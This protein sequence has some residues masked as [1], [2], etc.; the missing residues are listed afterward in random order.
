M[1][2]RRARTPS[3]NAAQ[4]AIELGR[5][6]RERRHVS[7]KT[8]VRRVVLVH[9]DAAAQAGLAE[10]REYVADELNALEVD[11][12]GD[13]A[14]WCTYVA[15]PDNAGLGKRLGADF[16]RVLPLIKALG[17]AEV[18]GFLET[19]SVTVGG[20]TLTGADLQARPRGG[21]R[22]GGGAAAPDPPLPACPPIAGPARGQGGARGA[23]RGGRLGGGGPARRRRRPPGAALGGGGGRAP[24]PR[25][26]PP[27]C[28]QDA[29][30]RAMG[31][32]REAVN[33]VQKL[34]KAS[35]L[36][37]SDAVDIYAAVEPLPA[38]AFAAFLA[39]VRRRW[40]CVRR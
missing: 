12:S 27:G 8:P 23:L 7:L 40:V 9:A 29:T 26:L 25:N 16:K 1:L 19:G 28:T 38:P 33:R 39:E 5:V 2:W 13:E 14:A 32:A 17:H 31:L 30:T 22:A 6:A 11:V 36:L 4:A 15:V 18:R 37:V 35:G 20:V 10:L 3:L 24:L 34:R 21:R